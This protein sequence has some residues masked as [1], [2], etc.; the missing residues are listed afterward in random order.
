MRPDS[1]PWTFAG[2]FGAFAI[3][4]AAADLMGLAPAPTAALMLAGTVAGAAACGRVR[5]SLTLPGDG[6][7]AGIAW[8]GG[9]FLLAWPGILFGAA[10]DGLALLAGAALGMLLIAL[11][12]ARADAPRGTAAWVLVAVLVLF[13]AANL[14]AVGRVLGLLLGLAPLPALA[15]ALLALGIA[16]LPGG[17]GADGNRRIGLYIVAALAVLVPAIVV[18][19]RFTGMPVPQIAL[20]EVLRRILETERAAGAAAIP[21]LRGQDPIGLALLGAT[22]ALGLAALPALTGPADRDRRR[23]AGWGLAFGALFLLTLP[24]HA[25]LLRSEI[26][27]NVL[28]R[29]VAGL[30][31]WVQQWSAPGRGLAAVCDR[32]GPGCATG[33]NADGVIQAE[34]LRLHPD[35]VLLAAADLG[36]LPPVLTALIAAGVLAAGLAAAGTALRAAPFRRAGGTPWLIGGGLLA[37]ALAAG[38]LASPFRLALFALVLAGAAL[39]PRALRRAEGGES[40]G[41]LTGAAV[42]LAL[43]GAS[44]FLGPAMNAALGDLA[45]LASIDGRPVARPFGWDN[46]AFGILGA[47]VGWLA[48]R[49][50]RS[51]G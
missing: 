29:T 15:V 33:G 11:G 25:A 31:V 18:G 9:A 12:T 17:P 50:A 14:A 44:E 32:P 35:V 7:G 47:P 43:V 49:L 23:R 13:A 26:D 45:P 46:I 38:D 24:V 42:C 37:A 22:M 8:I 16:F 51:A 21:F 34:E 1:L 40:I 28:G 30:P 48:A 27:G 19:A 5:G 41:A 20:V 6:M 3:A 10:Y 2:A 39:G 4:V 36:T